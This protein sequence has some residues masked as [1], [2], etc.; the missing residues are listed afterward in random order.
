MGKHR[1]KRSTVIPDAYPNDPKITIFD[2]NWQR[3]K[4]AIL[5]ITFD[6]L[7]KQ[8]SAIVG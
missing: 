5:G 1:R 2:E 6:S 4:C 7:T 3:S 8:P